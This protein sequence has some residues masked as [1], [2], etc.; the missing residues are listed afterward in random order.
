M[1]RQASCAGP[2][3]D[4]GDGGSG[5]PIGLTANCSQGGCTRKWDSG[6]K[7]TCWAVQ[8]RNRR[9]FG[10]HAAQVAVNTLRLR[11]PIPVENEALNTKPG[12]P[13][14]SSHFWASERSNSGAGDHR[15]QAPTS[16]QT[17]TRERCRSAAPTARRRPRVLMMN[18]LIRLPCAR[19]PPSGTPSQAP[20]TAVC[21]RMRTPW[22]HPAPAPTR[23]R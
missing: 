4:G 1:I 22:P 13:A 14:G 5:W 2:R 16:A 7:R 15:G 19:R 12:H 23:M 18:T 17:T 10:V 11:P 21:W 9:H 20:D 8:L 3:R 6:Q